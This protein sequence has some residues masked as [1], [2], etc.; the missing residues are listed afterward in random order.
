MLE[1]GIFPLP[2]EQPRL[3]AVQ[4]KLGHTAK[5]LI[6]N[7]RDSSSP[8]ELLRLTLESGQSPK[9]STGK[10]RGPY[11]GVTHTPRDGN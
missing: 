9:E 2:R 5:G 7:P 11:A 10:P 8:K 3:R 4:A 6:P 1:R